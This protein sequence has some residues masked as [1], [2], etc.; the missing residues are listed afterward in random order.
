MGERA[1]VAYFNNECIPVIHCIYILFE[2]RISSIIVTDI[3]RIY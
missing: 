3:G 1:G 2:I